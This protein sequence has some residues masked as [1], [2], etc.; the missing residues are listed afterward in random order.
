MPIPWSGIAISIVWLGFLVSELGG[1][2]L[3]D[4]AAGLGLVWFFVRECRQFS[5]FAWINMFAAAALTV[6]TLAIGRPASVL[7]TAAH[8]A[9]LLAALLTSMSF[10]RDPALVSPMVQSAG[11]ALVQQPPGRRYLT[12]TFG[13]HVFGLLFNYGA[14]TLLGSMVMSGN[15]LAANDGDEALQKRRERRMMLALLRGFQA[16]M[17]WSPMGVATALILANMPVIGWGDIAPYG[18]VAMLAFLTL[19]WVYDRATMPKVRI[20]VKV[21]PDVRLS[22][23]LPFTAL[24]AAIIAAA[25]V[26]EVVFGG[27]IIVWVIVV[28]PAVAV[29][30]IS[31][32]E[33]IGALGRRVRG[34]L[35]TEVPAS[36]QELVVLSVASFVGVL[37]AGMIPLD[38][39]RAGLAS[40]AVPPWAVILAVVWIIVGMGQ[41]GFSPIISATVLAALFPNPSAYGISAVALAQAIGGGWA[42]TVGSSHAIAATLIIARITGVPHTTI[43]RVWNRDFTI[44]ALLLMSGYVVGLQLALG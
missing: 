23:M 10:L 32:Q 11:R 42:L 27:R 5:R 20:P 2:R 8:Q 9:A 16:I 26:L 39:L 6:L 36:R 21:D 37:I 40:G 1:S 18:I 41:L 28:V 43:G 15:T 22:A 34:F 13:G 38:G 25:V 35:A 31:L 4:I 7:A 19:G 12:L 33:G 30:W 14:M 24:V 29:G 17:L 44:L 3:A